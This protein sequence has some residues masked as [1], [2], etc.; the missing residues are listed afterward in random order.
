MP[1]EF[2]EIDRRRP[3]LRAADADGADVA[4]PGLALS[5]AIN[6]F[7][8]FAGNVFPADDHELRNGEQ[9][10]R[11]D[12]LQ[13]PQLHRI[14]RGVA[15]ELVQLPMIDGVAVGRGARD[16]GGRDVPPAP[17]TFS[18]SSAGRANAHRLGEE[19]RQRIDRPAGGERH[20]DGD[21]PRRVRLRHRGCDCRR[22][23]NAAASRSFFMARS[24][25]MQ[26]D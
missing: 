5:H 19:P 7:T 25:P 24:A 4:L 18:R 10:H 21:R 3:G 26:P 15:D 12:F 6:S 17:P 14:D 13:H 20:D 23:A 8:F 1:V 11:L 2:L 9:R 22:V 16:A